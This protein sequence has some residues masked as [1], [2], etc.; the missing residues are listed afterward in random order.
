M[1]DQN[2]S[3]KGSPWTSPDLMGSKCGITVGY[4]VGQKS[5]IKSNEG[6]PFIGR[7]ERKS[8]IIKCDFINTDWR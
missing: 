8:K 1:N 5:M 4:L 3:K 6:V 7:C 2:I